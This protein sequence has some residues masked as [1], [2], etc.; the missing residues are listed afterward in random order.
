MIVS[1]ANAEAQLAQCQGG[2]RAMLTARDSR[3]V[4]KSNYHAYCTPLWIRGG[5]FEA[6]LG[7]DGKPPPLTSSPADR[8]LLY[9]RENMVNHFYFIA[10]ILLSYEYLER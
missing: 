1:P 6:C 5:Q 7:F 3:G 9:R 8:Y 10:R 4:E 2:K